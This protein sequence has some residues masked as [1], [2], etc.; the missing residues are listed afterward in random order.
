VARAVLGAGL[1]CPLT[2]VVALVP[3]P[4]IVWAQAAVSNSVT[5]AVS[6][7][8]ARTPR[9]PTGCAPTCPS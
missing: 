9:S 1:S 8:T 7:T 6:I 3:D 2:G 4:L 5:P